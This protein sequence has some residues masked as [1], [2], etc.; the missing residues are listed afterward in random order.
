LHYY[1][2]VKAAAKLKVNLYKDLKVIVMSYYPAVVDPAVTHFKV[3]SYMVGKTA[4]EK[5]LDLLDGKEIEPRLFPMEFIVGNSCGC[6]VP[7]N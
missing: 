1:D 2:L 6:P 4:A 7:G 3:P 5:L